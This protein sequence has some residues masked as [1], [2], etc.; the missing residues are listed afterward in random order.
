M[1]TELGVEDTGLLG[2]DEGVL[3]SRERKAST[4]RHGGGLQRQFN[5]VVGDVVG[6]LPKLD[7]GVNVVVRHGGGCV[8]ARAG[9]AGGEGGKE[10]KKLISFALWWLVNLSDWGGFNQSE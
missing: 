8:C 7:L 9:K 2:V 1:S 10:E 3:D 5:G 4:E 6:V